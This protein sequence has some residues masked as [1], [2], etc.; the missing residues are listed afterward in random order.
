MLSTHRS[1]EQFVDQ[2]CTDKHCLTFPE[3]VQKLLLFDSSPK[4]DEVNKSG[5]VYS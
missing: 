3:S 2:S 4:L 5:Q 1:G